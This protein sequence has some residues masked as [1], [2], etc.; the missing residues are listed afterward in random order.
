MAAVAGVRSV[1]AQ[2]LGSGVFELTDG[3]VDV[4]E[5][6]V[7]QWIFAEQS[8]TP[9]QRFDHLE[10]VAR[11][12]FIQF[13]EFFDSHDSLSLNHDSQTIHPFR[14]YH[15][16]WLR[17]TQTTITGDMLSKVTLVLGK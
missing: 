17:A 6:A 14:A 9:A 1:L 11:Q 10:Q 7:V 13:I 12:S 15:R 2:Q 8:A 3:L 4:T 16:R 5:D